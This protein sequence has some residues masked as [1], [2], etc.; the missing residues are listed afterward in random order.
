MR[1]GESNQTVDEDY[2]LAVL[3]EMNILD[4]DPELFFEDVVDNIRDIFK[5][6]VAIVSF[7]DQDRQFL[8][9]RRGLDLCNTSRENSICAIAMFETDGLMLEDASRD[10]R[11]KRNPAVREDPGVAAYLGVPIIVR[12]NVPVGAVSA[13]D[14]M[15]R[16][17]TRADRNILKRK[18]RQLATHIEMR[19]MFLKRRPKLVSSL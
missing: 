9:A 1:L 10:P 2:S 3:H 5:V 13:V 11:F 7:V 17:W 12:D 16:Q 15:P 18:A 4:T 14:F 6:P 19:A 8:K